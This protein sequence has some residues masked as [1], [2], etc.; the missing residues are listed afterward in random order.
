MPLPNKLPTLPTTAFVTLLILIFPS[1]PND[2]IIGGLVPF[3][4]ELADATDA[5]AVPSSP[6]KLIYDRESEREIK[7]FSSVVLS[8]SEDEE[9]LTQPHQDDCSLSEHR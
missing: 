4:A 7:T 8:M 2:S 5:A 3:P 9:T 6:S 1:S